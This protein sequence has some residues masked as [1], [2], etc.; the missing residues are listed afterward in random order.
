M[1][2]QMTDQ[3]LTLALGHKVEFPWS[4]S[5]S[6]RQVLTWE[7]LLVQL[8]PLDLEFTDPPPSFPDLHYGPLS[9]RTRH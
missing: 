8:S 9:D 3:S 2:V 7:V 4:L 5:L 1:I 6:I